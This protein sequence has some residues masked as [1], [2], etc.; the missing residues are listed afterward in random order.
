MKIEN[1]SFRYDDKYIFKDL[2]LDLP[3]KLYSI[4]GDSGIGKTTLLKLM[5]GLLVP[6]SGRI[7]DAP[8][9]PSFMFQEDRL[10]P[11]LNVRKNI[12]LVT[13]NS[14]KAERLLDTLAIDGKLRISELSGGMAR[15]VALIRAL[16]H[17]GDALFLDEPFNG[18]DDRLIDRCIELIHQEDRFTVISAHQMEVHEKLGSKL[19]R[20]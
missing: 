15:R 7:T 16:C 18:M 2:S 17:D 1:I 9:K 14:E 11:W 4:T 5:G 19:I 13:E 8:L 3:G 10:L 6:E 12:S 20:L